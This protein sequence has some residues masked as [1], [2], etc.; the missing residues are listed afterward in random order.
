MM[1]S[2]PRRANRARRGVLSSPR[3]A[4]RRVGR[5]RGRPGFPGRPTATVARVCARRGTAAGAA[6]SRDC[7]Q[8]RSPRHRPAPAT[9][10]P[11]RVS[12]SRLWAPL[13]RGDEA[14]I[15]TTVIPAPFLLVIELGQEGPPPLEQYPG[16]CPR[17]EPPPDGTGAARPPGQLTPW[18][19]RPQDPE[20]PLQTAPIVG[21][22]PST[23]GGSLGLREMDTSGVP[24]LLCQSAPRHV[25]PA[26]FARELMA[27][28]DLNRQV[29]K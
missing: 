15:D 28:S 1:G 8:R 11:G 10:C 19:A 25:L 7:S 18:G 14:A 29:L 3:A 4:I 23:S 12:S 9:S 21:A 6:A 22:R 2:M 5:L 13:C 24:L 17:R 20:E 16:L 26:R 27:L